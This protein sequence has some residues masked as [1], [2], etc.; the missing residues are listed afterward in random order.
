[1]QEALAGLTGIA[2]VDQILMCEGIPLAG[3]KPLSAYSLPVSPYDPW[4][5]LP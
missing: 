1:M 4:A 2:A 3:F 5:L